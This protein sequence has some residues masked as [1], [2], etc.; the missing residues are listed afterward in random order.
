MWIQTPPRPK[1][2]GRQ[3]KTNNNLILHNHGCAGKIK[4]MTIY[5]ELQKILK[6]NRQAILCLV[7]KTTGSTPRHAGSKM[8]VLPDGSFLGTIGGGEIEARVI[9][10]ALTLFKKCGTKNLSYDLVSPE[11]GDPGICGGTVE[12]FLEFVGSAHRIIVIGAGHVGQA[13][14]ELAKWMDFPTILLDDRQEIIN[15]LP[16]QISDQLIQNDPEHLLDSL[17]LTSRDFVVMTTRGYDF[18]IKI[19]PALLKTAVEYIGVIGSKRRWLTTKKYLLENGF[20]EDELKKISSPIGL[21]LQAETP[22]EI[23]LSILGEIYTVK[24][25]TNASSMRI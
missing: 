24:N 17:Q 18:D 13:V 25:N 8:L 4:T 1:E 16:D 15:Q 21:D 9:Q 6:E 23:A 20:T 12:V 7:T 14:S 11:Q 5:T 22:K 3:Y 19:L 10:E 2:Y